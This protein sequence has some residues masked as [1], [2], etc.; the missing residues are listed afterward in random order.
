LKPEAPAKVLFFEACSASEGALAVSFAGAS[1]FN[2]PPGAIL[3]P[4]NNKARS[5]IN[6]SGPRGQS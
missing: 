4:K 6:P 1:G 5:G 3:S 2:F